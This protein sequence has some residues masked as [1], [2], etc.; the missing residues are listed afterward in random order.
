MVIS[1]PSVSYGRKTIAKFSDAAGTLSN[2]AATYVA[3]V[4][5]RFTDSARKGELISG[6]KLG[7]L[8]KVQVKVGF[9]YSE[10]VAFG[11]VVSGRMTLTKRDGEVIKRDLACAR[12]RK[13]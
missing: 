2:T 4:D 1:D 8:A 5:L 10:P 7:E 6:T 12:Y 11:E 13:N 9:S 3:K